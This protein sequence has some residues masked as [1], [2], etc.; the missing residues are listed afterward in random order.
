MKTKHL[1]ALAALMMLALM[2]S[3]CV[4]NNQAEVPEAVKGI[5]GL[6]KYQTKIDYSQP[7][8][9]LA[10]PDE[11][12]KPVDVFFIYPTVTGYR[13]NT[14]VCD[15]NDSVMVA[16]AHRVFIGQTSVF[17]ESCNVF[18]PYYRQISLPPKGTD[19]QA[20]VDYISQFDATD[21]LDYYLNNLNQDRPFIIAG[22]SQG[23]STVISLLE[24]YIT[25]HPE[26]LS[27]MVAAYPIGFSVTDKWLEKTGL[28][29]AE[30]AT[31]LGVIITWNTEGP[32][33]H[34]ASSVVVAPGAIS[35]NPINWKRDDT[36]APVEDNLGSL[37][38]E[39]A[40]IDVPG[41]ADA[42]VDTERG[43]VVVTTVD[44][45]KY[46][47]PEEGWP[48][49]GPECYHVCDYSFFYNN[50]RQNVADR[51]AAWLLLY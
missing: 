8:Y 22:H 19:Y 41:I 35:I 3:S 10:L 42:R 14:E 11:I 48:L 13:G 30:S 40:S 17:A 44:P 23:A 46:A 2:I 21:A 25:K 49:F 31:D 47:I 5:V 34:D 16:G 45:A 26:V 29:F 39:T 6:E 43:V 4:T 7:Q 20:I 51:I 15:I 24:N 38:Y 1:F 50:I 12:T 36:Y 32:G 18:M 28:K 9:W 27:R 37:N 33:N